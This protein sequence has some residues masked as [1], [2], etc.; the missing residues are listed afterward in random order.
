MKETTFKAY[1][2]R[3]LMLAAFMVIAAVNQGLWITFAP[4]TSEAMKFY[5]ASDLAIGL[6]SLCFMAVF[7]VVFLPA[8]WLIDTWGIRPTVSLGALLTA[9]FAM[10]R[11][12]FASNFTMVVVSQIGIAIGQPLVIGATTKLAGRW[13]PATERATAT[14][15]GTLAIYV[16][17]LVSLTVTPALT[18][19]YGIRGTLIALGGVAVVAALF[20]IL[21]ARERPATPVGRPKDEVRSLM[22]DG[23][24]SM[25]QK[26]DFLFLLAI[27]FVGLGMFNGITTW[28]EEIVAPR[29]FSTSQAGL[30]GGL[31]LIGGIVGAVA[32]PIVSDTIRRRKPFIIIALIG[33]LP[34]LLGVTLAGSYWL[35]LA[36][37][38]VFGFFL[39]S[40]G[41]VG[42]QYGAEMTLPAPEGTSNTLL[43]LAGQVSGI[44]I[45]F[46]MDA[47]KGP[48]GSMTASLLGLVGLALVVLV[49]ASFMKESPIS[50]A[51]GKKRARTG[52]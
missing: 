47:L 14:G 46:L 30:A 2:Y 8:A 44:I 31:M 37:S 35:L 48:R 51:K 17:I 9:V 19:A 10:T 33:L 45:I 26:R 40:A 29:G 15:L 20:F 39:L 38:F 13:F 16:G 18:A 36:S 6:L 11:G 22:F 28:I 23:L 43:I 3:W 25:I 27:F 7:I 41:P 21:V 4:I 5:S 1:H 42:F 12:L 50:V 52:K 32:L 24:R 49:L 34:G